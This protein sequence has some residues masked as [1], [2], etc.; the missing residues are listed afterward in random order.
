MKRKIYGLVVF[1]W[2]GLGGFWAA[3]RFNFHPGRRVGQPIDSLNGVAVYYNGGVGHV[4][5]RHLAANGP[6]ASRA[7]WAGCGNPDAMPSFLGF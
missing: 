1:L 5:G 4:A 6:S 2:L 7:L 3:Q